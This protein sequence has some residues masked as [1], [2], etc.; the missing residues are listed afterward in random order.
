MAPSP[1]LQVEVNG[2]NVIPDDERH[3]TPRS[4]F[5]PWA[6]ASISIFNVS[7]AAL[8][9]AFGMGFMAAAIAALIGITVS[10]FLVGLISLAGKRA[11]APTMVISRAAFGVHGNAVPTA[12]SYLTLVGWEIVVVATTVMAATTVFQ[13][14][15]WADGT[16]VEGAVFALVVAVV[17]IAGV[18][19]IRLVTRFQAVVTVA[20]ILLTVAY[21]AMTIGT[22]NWSAL[23]APGDAGIGE[24][25]GAIVVAMAAFGL[26][27]TNSGADYSRYLPRNASG[28][29]IVGWTT[30][31]GS[32]VPIV[33]VVYGLM[34]VA[35]DPG[36]AGALSDNPIG[37]LISLLPTSALIL[38]PFLLIM[39]LGATGSGAMDLYSS[40]FSLLTLGL[41][42]PRAVA[43]GIDG[44]LMTLGSV[45]LLWFAGS[46]FGPFE[47]F[48]IFLGV[49][50][51]AWAG[52]FIADATSRRQD[53]A[54]A[55]LNDPAGRYGSV[56]WPALASMVAATIIGWGLVVSDA[57]TPLLSWQGF[58]F[59]ALGIPQDSVWRACNVGV[60]AALVIGFAG[61]WAFG[62]RRIARQEA[63]GLDAAS[64]LRTHQGAAS[65][66][67]A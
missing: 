9:A 10:F 18:V 33:L 42:V 59:D 23:T 29:A 44:V 34:L 64:T 27:W 52:V 12:I 61:A 3:G 54:G 15:G 55:E 1:A 50:L 56:G 49:P 4:L 62:R 7:I 17:V 57:S 41:K 6:T 47:G 14:L 36:M 13:R 38:L 43:A 66:A 19:G 46:F 58:I 39:S 51:A 25:I 65:G 35:S 28:R 37:A 5:W 48:L 11:A 2:I 21:I 45:Y 20:C 16:A 24:F 30:F 31:A 60:L 40:G 32:L 22:V 8:L 63:A 67:G 53:Y 26:G